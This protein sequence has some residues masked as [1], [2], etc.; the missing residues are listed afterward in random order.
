MRQLWTSPH[1]VFQGINSTPGGGGG[2]GCRRIGTLSLKTYVFNIFL[3]IKNILS[4][5]VIIKKKGPDTL[6]SY[7][8]KPHFKYQSM[9]FWKVS[10]I[11]TVL[12]TLDGAILKILNMFLFPVQ[13]NSCFLFDCSLMGAVPQ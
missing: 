4:P 10:H 5:D 7:I 11:F 2:W 1:A 9:V 12:L 8:F 6:S 3:F 13:L